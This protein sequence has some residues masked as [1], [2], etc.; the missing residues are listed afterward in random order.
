MNPKQVVFWHR[1]LPPVEA[2]P[3]VEDEIEATGPRLP[4]SPSGRSEL[5][6]RSADGLRASAESRI[7]QEVR[8]LGGLY[9]HVNDDHVEEH[10]D[11]AS[12]ET[13]LR[14][15]YSFVVYR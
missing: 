11:H 15:R 2:E 1:D 12:G 14:G 7:A 9:A 10:T 13:W 4:S 3:I 6:T 5:W 8:R